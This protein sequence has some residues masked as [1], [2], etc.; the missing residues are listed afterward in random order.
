MIMSNTVSVTNFRNNIF[1]YID[2]AMINQKQVGIMNNKIVVGWFVPNTVRVVTK[3]D[4]V[5]L[6]LEEIGELQKKYPIR[7]GKNLSQD[8]DK[9]LYGQ[10]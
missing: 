4:K 10:K 1:S 6:F 7:E 2:L 8:I 9:I 5:D 3:K